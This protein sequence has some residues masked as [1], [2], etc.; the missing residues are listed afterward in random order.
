MRTSVIGDLFAGDG[1]F[2]EEA[3]KRGYPGWKYD[4]LYDKI[5]H[6]IIGERGFFTALDLVL[7]IKQFGFLMCG[8]PCGLFIFLS[9]SYHQRS[10]KQPWGD[11]GKLYVR[12]ANQIMINLVVL[13]AIAHERF[14]FLGKPSS[15]LSAVRCVCIYLLLY[16]KGP[17]LGIPLG[18]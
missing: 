11:L 14:V 8:P 10:Q 12:Q 5:L 13:M 17:W 7:S 9:I 18:S 4:I 16:V 3:M 1:H 2:H 15:Y 6:N